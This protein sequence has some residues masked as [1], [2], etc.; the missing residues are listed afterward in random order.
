M[1][2]K[3]WGC[4]QITMLNKKEWQLLQLFMATPNAYLTSKELSEQ[5]GFSD[6]TV[7][8]YVNHLAEAL[9]PHG[10]MIER[11][12]GHGYKFLEVDD[13]AFTTFVEAER[14]Q[15]HSRTDV[16]QL[17][18]QA[19]RQRYIL[20][21][22]F[23]EEERVTIAQLAELL[24]VS[25]TTIANLLTGI[26]QL[27]T[28]YQLVLENHSAKGMVIVGKEQ[29]KRRFMMDYFFTKR[30]EQSFSSYVGNAFLTEAIRMEE[31]TII[32]LD[33][34]REAKLKL[35][36]YVIHNLV[37][38]LSLAIQRLKAGFS[39]EKFPLSQD[40]LNS[41]EYEVA[42]RIIRRIEASLHIAF[43]K[44]EANYVALHL[45]VKTTPYGVHKPDA[46]ES[47]DEMM[48]QLEEAI[49]VFSERVDVELS[50]DNVLLNGLYAHFIPFLVR[51]RNH[52]K[53]ENPLLVDIQQR[54][55]NELAL[56]YQIFAE[57][58]LL[59]A[60]EISEDEWAY[61]AL[62]MM[63]AIERYHTK[64]RKRVLVICATG[65][66]S[67]QMLKNRLEAEFGNQMHIVDV[68]S[69]YEITE[70]LLT[71]VDLI[72]SSI[73]LANIILPVPAIHVSVFLAEEDIQKVRK[74][75]GA[76]NEK[77]TK[78]AM[79]EQLHSS[80]AAAVFDRTFSAERFILVSQVC[81]RRELLAQM[82]GHLEQENAMFADQMMRQIDLRE[83][84][85][86]VVFNRTMAFP[87]PATPLSTKAQVVVALCQQGVDWNEE[88]PDVQLVCLMSP[89]QGRNQDM[90]YIS[91]AFVQLVQSP[92]LQKQLMRESDFARFRQIF[93]PL[94]EQEI[95]K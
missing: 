65:Y 36:D 28:K 32:V 64:Q 87:H 82:I 88:H 24:Y 93:I 48:H 89:S 5:L 79:S 77:V 30:Y 66:G 10:G 45:K 94:I 16:T 6:K 68:I 72:I 55:P 11:A 41:S 57:M 34:C 39:L 81:E 71:G 62:H 69:Y 23:F 13:V 51:L 7:R 18:E 46:G 2:E 58:P 56:T 26:R 1:N 61:I 4:K 75:L 19:D 86:P 20:H 92:E 63:A 73:S 60:F 52:I 35:S 15:Q 33:E 14:Q 42:L 83:N 44:E 27:L 59:Q 47:E 21:L 78:Q 50:E 91:R 9:L 90:V 25:R 31:L 29:N 8:K 84:M 95:N 22:L 85:G 54:Y 37:L 12:Q 17:E 43:P 40:V 76:S 53:L 3:M 67:A 74:Q 49:A 38:H 80:E 70:Q